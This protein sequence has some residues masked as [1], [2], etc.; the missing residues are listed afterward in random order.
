[1]IFL[2][3]ATTQAVDEVW[4]H[5][6]KEW[7]AQIDLLTAC[8]HMGPLPAVV[9][10]AGGLIYLMLGFNFYRWLVTLNAAFVGAVVGTYIGY[11][12]GSA[13]PG[14][15]LGGFCA[16]AVTWPC[17]RWAVA[18]MGGIFGALLGGSLWRA[19]GLDPHYLWTGAAMGLIFCGLVCFIVFRGSVMAYT[20]LQGSVMLVFG[21]L[22]LIFKYQNLSSAIIQGLTLKPFLLPMAIFIPAILGLMYQQNATAAVQAKK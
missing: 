16:A 13:L 21:L 17:M 19:A 7:P 12:M 20:S 22:G 10:I 14:G 4:M 5:V 18:V 15:I 8:Q 6:P 11:K 2:A 3:Q 9:L 1:M